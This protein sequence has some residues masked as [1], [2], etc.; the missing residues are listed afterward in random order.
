[1]ACRLAATTQAIETM[2]CELVYI[3][4]PKSGSFAELTEHLTRERA[5]RDV[6][7]VVRLETGKRW[8]RLDTLTKVADGLN[9][10]VDELL[11]GVHKPSKRR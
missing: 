11:K 5:A 7:S 8:P 6:K 1:M 10:S 2:G 3:L 4:I 9:I